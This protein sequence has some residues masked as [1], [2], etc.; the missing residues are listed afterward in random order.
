MACET[1][2]Q[3]IFNLISPTSPLPLPNLNTFRTHSASHPYLGSQSAH[4]FQIIINT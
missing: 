2:F 3:D 1:Q 4:F